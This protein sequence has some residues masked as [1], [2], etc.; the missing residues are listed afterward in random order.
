MDISGY[1]ERS[2]QAQQAHPQKHPV[3][4]E[5]GGVVQEETRSRGIRQVNPWDVPLHS[6]PPERDVRKQQERLVAEGQIEPIEL[7]P[8]GRANLDEWVYADAQ[9]EAAR[10]LKWPTI[11]VTP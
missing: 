7:S 1:I 8:D 5:I 4:L 3:Q 10:R 11:L 6:I 9:I 2:R